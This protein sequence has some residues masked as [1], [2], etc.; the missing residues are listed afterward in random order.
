MIYFYAY[1]RCSNPILGAE[2]LDNVAILAEYMEKL[3]KLNTFND[4]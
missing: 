1:F 3:S 4:N 2:I